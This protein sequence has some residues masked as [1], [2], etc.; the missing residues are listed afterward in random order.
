[1]DDII[2]FKDKWQ[3]MVDLDSLEEVKR[4][5]SEECTCTN[6]SVTKFNDLCFN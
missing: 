1:M 2:R 6:I 3:L 5:P 4:Y